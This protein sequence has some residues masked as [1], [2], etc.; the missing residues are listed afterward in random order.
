MKKRFLNFIFGKTPI[1]SMD[2][3]LNIAKNECDQREWGW[4]EPVEIKRGRKAWKIRTNAK[5]LGTIAVFSIDHQTGEV[6][7]AGY[8]SR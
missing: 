6:L 7:R 4:L 5:S 8:V 2:E 3:A 1:I